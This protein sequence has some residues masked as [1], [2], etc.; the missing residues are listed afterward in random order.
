MLSATSNIHLQ[1]MHKCSVSEI[2]KAT[3]H[4]SHRRTYGVYDYIEHA[5]AI[6][7]SQDLHFFAYKVMKD[8]G[9]SVVGGGAAILRGTTANLHCICS[10]NLK[11]VKHYRRN[12]LSH[13]P[14]ISYCKENTTPHVWKA[15]TDIGKLQ[16]LSPKMADAI[17]Q[18]D[19]QSIVTFPAHGPRSLIGGFRYLCDREDK[20]TDKDV[21][22][23]LP[24]LSLVNIYLYEATIRI[25][26]LE[27]QKD[28]QLTTKEKDILSWLAVGLNSQGISERAHISENTVHYHMKNIHKKLEVNNRHHAVAKALKLNLINP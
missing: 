2:K 20:L 24:T 16:R 4:P 18:F 8:F 14:L 28:I 21:L 6:D 5:L 10:G 7:T 9:Y 15:N 3:A 19:I 1:C 27:V 25:L 17:R 22:Q 12:L 26:D 13:D 23:S 11:W